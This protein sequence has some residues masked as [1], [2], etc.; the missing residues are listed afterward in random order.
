MDLKAAPERLEVEPKNEEWYGHQV[1]C[2]AAF[3]HNILE[4][5][6]L[7]PDP[8]RISP[9]ILSNVPY[10][11]VYPSKQFHEHSSATF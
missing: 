6:I 7:N 11:K 3:T 9:K 1:S 10:L 2:A 4:K 5:L 8:D